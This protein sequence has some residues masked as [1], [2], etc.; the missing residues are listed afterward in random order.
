MDSV[1]MVMTRRPRLHC[2]RIDGQGWA[3]ARRRGTSSLELGYGCG[4]LFG[5][6]NHPVLK[7]IK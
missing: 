6:K 4:L 1:Y 3:R 2:N 5:Y 7:I